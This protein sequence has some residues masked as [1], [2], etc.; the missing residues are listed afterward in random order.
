MTEDEYIKN[1]YIR[2]DAVLEKVKRSMVDND[3]PRIALPPDSAKLLYLLARIRGAKK[4]LEIGTLA[5]YSTIWLA[6]ALPEGGSVLTLELEEDFARVASQNFAM[7]GVKDKI[8]IRVGEALNSL[9][10]LRDS[11]ETFDFFF[12]D[13]D[14]IHYPDYLEMVIEMA[15]PGALITADNTF[16]GGRVLDPADKEETTE[17][18]RRFNRMLSAGERLEAIIVP[19][20]D[21]LAVAR[22]KD[23]PGN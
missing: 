7:A 12:I 1:L 15:E 8:T 18:I 13:A 9:R 6:R 17:K 16:W 3:M 14:K 4:I 22:V 5:G 10:N 23:L 2:E 20:G 19:T 11:G 21:G